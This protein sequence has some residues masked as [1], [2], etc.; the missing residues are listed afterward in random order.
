MATAEAKRAE[1]LRD[2]VRRAY[3]IDEAAAVAASVDEATPDPELAARTR[4][5][6]EALVDGMRASRR[7]F[8][9][10]DDFLQEFGLS[11]KEGVA[12]MCLAEALQRVPDAETANRLIRDKIGSLP[13][14]TK[15]FGQERRSLFVN[16]STMGADADRQGSSGRTR[17]L[18]RKAPPVPSCAASWRALGEPV[19][20]ER[21][22]RQA[23][24]HPRASQFVIEPHHRGGA[25]DNGRDPSRAAATAT[26]TTCWARAAR[27]MKDAEHYFQKPTKRRSRPSARHRA[28]QRCRRTGPGSRSSSR[29]CIRVTSFGPGGSPGHGR[30]R[31]RAR[32][33][34]SHGMR[35]EALDIGFNIDAEEAD[36][37]DIVARTSSSRSR[38]LDLELKATGTALASSMQAYQKRAPLPLVDYGWPTWR[39]AH[40]RRLM[41]RLV[42][43]AYW[44]TEIKRSQELGPRPIIRCSRANPR[45][46]RL[47]P[48]LC[49][50]S[51]SPTA[52][53]SIRMFASAQCPY[54][55]HGSRDSPA[56]FRGLRV[57]APARH[58]RAALRADRRA[59]GDE[60]GVGCRIY[61]P[62][63]EP[64]GSA[65]LPRPPPPGERRQHLL[66]QPHPRRQP[67]DRADRRPPGRGG[68][69]DPAGGAPENPPAPRPLRR[70]A[71][72]RQG[73]QPRRSLGGLAPGPGDGGVPDRRLARRADRGRRSFAS[74]TRRRRSIPP[75]TGGGSARS[76]TRPTP[77]RRR[78]SPRPRAP[79]PAGTRRRPASGRS[80][81]TDWPTSWNR[82]GRS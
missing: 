80:A 44:D 53:P 6:A 79:S 74:A 60:V 28:R 27:T 50:A 70:R 32:H 29:H 24:A 35:A 69:R 54:H 17:T 26:P 61:A 13:I 73:H 55:R 20:R 63:G 39:G 34:A 78:R 62:V 15:H 7:R 47:L 30:T 38:H 58:G 23:M 14:G 64:R 41:V 9:G 81:S 45:N 4:A 76:R 67:A 52:T 12:L 33:E 19:V 36:R 22:Q 11:T 46:R 21:R 43:G 40:E 48:R 59:E 49:E 82:T 18:A 8:G 66:R 57:P 25:L 16:A 3:R 1:R 71:T 77:T 31:D 42:K 2:S 68:G 72:Q 75:I 65:G 10:L 56:I 5:R 37:L 51:C